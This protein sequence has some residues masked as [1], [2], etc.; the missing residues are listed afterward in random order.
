MNI[1]EF[2][3]KTLPLSQGYVVCVDDDDY[4]WASQWKW[5]A[6]V[7]GRKR[8]IVYAI[9]TRT[10]TEI[11]NKPGKRMV[12]MHREL[13]D[14]V[15]GVVDHK[16]HD[17]LNNRRN[18]IRHTTQKLNA[19]NNRKEIGRHGFKGV[20]QPKGSK[21]FASRL[22]KADGSVHLGMFDTIEDAARAYD[23]AAIKE[24]GEFAK[25]NFPLAPSLAS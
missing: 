13:L 20:H 4:E 5:C 14:A 1:G 7:T 8:Q 17:G 21:R 11:A 16:D 3:M 15:G 6:L 18:N 22:S 19:A 9:R 2:E 23:A 24:F 10:H 12:L 25:L